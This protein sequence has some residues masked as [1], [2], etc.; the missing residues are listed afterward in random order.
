MLKENLRLQFQ[1][2]Q[3]YW[4]Q[5]QPYTFSSEVSKISAS[6][7]TKKDVKFTGKHGVLF[8]VKVHATDLLYI[9]YRDFTWFPGQSYEQI[10]QKSSKIVHLHK[11]STPVS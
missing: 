11:I 4:R 7:R 8:L 9:N 10:T 5:V 3:F 2:L 1:S 6:S